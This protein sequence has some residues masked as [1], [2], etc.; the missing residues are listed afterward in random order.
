MCSPGGLASLSGSAF[1][2]Q[3]PQQAQSLEL[4]TRLA[5]VQVNV[6]GEAAGL[7]FVSASRVNFQCPQGTPGA[8]LDVTVE[9]EDGSIQKVAGSSMAAV[10]PGIFTVD[11]SN[12]GVVQVASTHEMAMAATEGIASRPARQGEMLAIYAMG[13]GSA[14]AAYP[15]QVAIGDMYTDAESVNPVPS[16][17][18][19]FRIEFAVP[20]GTPSGAAVPLHLEV[21]LPDQTSVWSNAVTVAIE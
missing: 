9:A 3:N 6:N 16:A 20:Q 19:L 5:G 17:A 1:T 18:G 14:A 10:A 8:A 12:Q 4:P 13:L 15:V 11:A 2:S 7:S 21:T